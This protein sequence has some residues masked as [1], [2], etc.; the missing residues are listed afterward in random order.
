MYLNITA[1][2]P[3]MSRFSPFLSFPFV[4]KKG[5]SRDK[6]IEMFDEPEPK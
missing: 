2:Y 1:K 4:E 6:N 5:A 3:G